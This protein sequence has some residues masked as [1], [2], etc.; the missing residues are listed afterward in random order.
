[1]LNFVN[2]VKTFEIY[3][4]CLVRPAEIPHH[5]FSTTKPISGRV[6]RAS[7]TEAVDSGSIPGR[8]KPK[9]INIG[10]HC[11]AFSN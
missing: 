10:I 8:V 4:D 7:A 3:L 6:D 9:T 2:C 5:D 11:L 1:M